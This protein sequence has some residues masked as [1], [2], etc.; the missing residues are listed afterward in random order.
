MEYDGKLS[1]EERELVIQ[2]FGELK[3]AQEKLNQNDIF[4]YLEK[5]RKNFL[6]KL[7]L[8]GGEFGICDSPSAR[9][10]HRVFQNKK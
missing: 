7:G 3:P 2:E 5:A 8:I 6:G 9:Y 1:K 4:V 10:A